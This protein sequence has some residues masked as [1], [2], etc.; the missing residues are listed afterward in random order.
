M[1]AVE[2]DY[3]EIIKLILSKG[4]D[5]NENLVFIVFNGIVI[6]LFQ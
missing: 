5:I 3:L 1:Y 4:F 6:F 2:K